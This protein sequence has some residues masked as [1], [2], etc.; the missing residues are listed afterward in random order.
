MLVN[1]AFSQTEEPAIKAPAIGGYSPVSYFTKNIA[2]IGSPEFAVEHNGVIYHLMSADQ[3]KVFEENPDKYR[4]KYK[5]CPYSLTLGKVLPLDPT[6]FKIVG[7]NLLLFHL[8]DDEN[9]LL[10]WNDS[11]VSE[12]EL[13]RRADANL[14]L[15]E[16]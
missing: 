8:S 13:T 2:E 12:A 3:I 1:P 16:F 10:L 15:V 6:N 9:A 7:G 5:S 14:F 4:P 11:D